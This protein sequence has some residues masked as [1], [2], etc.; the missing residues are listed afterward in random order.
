MELSNFK[1]SLYACL[2]FETSG[3][4]LPFKYWDPIVQ[5]G[6]I[7]TKEHKE[8]CGY[9]SG[10]E[11]YKDG[12]VD[13]GGETKFGIAKVGDS[14]LDITNL[15]LAQAEEI[16][17][18]RYWKALNIDSLHPHVA[19]YVF[20]IAM[21]SWIST[22]AKV[23]QRAIGVVDDGKIGPKTIEKANSLDPD[24]VI[25]NMIFWRLKYY[26]ELIVKHPSDKAFIGGWT[27]RARKFMDVYK[28]VK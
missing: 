16:Y 22:A 5:K 18:K 4:Y 14:S 9:T 3:G 13:R 12:A 17:Y 15:T 8:W 28:S 10:K 6:I 27:N 11:V 19:A 23:L 21:G 20:D 7:D 2:S 26:Q 1:K 25:K 24:E